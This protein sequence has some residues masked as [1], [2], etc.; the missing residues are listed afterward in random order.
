MFALCTSLTSFN[1][2][3]LGNFAH[4]NYLRKMN[5]FLAGCTSLVSADIST[6]RTDALNEFNSIFYRCTSLKNVYLSGINT[7]G[8]E[9]FKNVFTNCSSLT[10]IDLSVID[11]QNARTFEGMFKGCSS[12]QT[13]NLQNLN[14]EKVNNMS[15]LFCD[16][17]SLRNVTL[18]GTNA[19]GFN[20]YNLKNMSAIFKNCTSLQN[21][22]ISNLSTSNVVDMSE[23][24]SGC[25]G[26]K[27]LD[28]KTTNTDNVQNMN[29]MF[30]NC[31]GL[32][33][34]NITN[35][36]MSNVSSC[37]DFLTGCN[38]LTHFYTPYKAQ[39]INLPGEFY[40]GTN[41][42]DT[43]KYTSITSSTFWEESVH[44]TKVKTITYHSND[45]TS[46]SYKQLKPLTVPVR[47]KT[48]MF[49]EPAGREFICWNTKS[50]GT[51]TRYNVDTDFNVDA[52]TN[53]YAQWKL[54]QYT[55]TFKNGSNIVKSQRVTYGGNAT[56][57][58][59]TKK[60][61]TLTWDK[62]YNNIQTDLVIN[63]VWIPKAKNTYIIQYFK[64]NVDQTGYVL[65]SSLTTT[66]SAVVGTNVYVMVNDEKD[67]EG[68]MYNRNCKYN[69]LSG[70]VTEDNVLVLKM[71]YDRRTVVKEIKDSSGN[72]ITVIDGKY[73]EEIDLPDDI[74][75]KGKKFEGWEDENGNKIDSIYIEDITDNY[76]RPIW[77]DDPD[78]YYVDPKNSDILYQYD[79]IIK[80]K[81]GTKV[82]DLLDDIDTN[83]DK[84][85]KDKYGNELGDNDKVKT[86]DILEIEYEGEI[87][88][89]ELVV[90]GDV[91]GDGLVSLIDLSFINQ[92]MIGK[93]KLTGVKEK[94]ADVNFDYRI[95]LIDLSFVNQHMIGKTRL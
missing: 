54:K 77:T 47:V 55:V 73:G 76:P 14:T 27:K 52:D 46:N 31:T 36:N 53:L 69:V 45:G 13:I 75:K 56:P 1:P 42:E 66:K 17:T 74:T 91:N 81:P 58:S 84:R 41:I 21:I 68:F 87:H 34:L 72:V 51:G 94:A 16:C 5:S 44:L 62:S 63:A 86:G 70:K 82:D 26:L 32:T 12:L 90:R 15:Q 20:T 65:D 11:T 49:T 40:N 7:S 59:I 83:G 37:N 4:R 95:S 29:E 2:G 71:Y 78:A 92:H 35:F 38:S 89:Y 19:Y 28:L 67:I 23:L 18:K 60:D 30:K 9:Q 85:I 25:T 80:I 43:K 79:Y 93:I 24:F 8:I 39:T 33:E 88:I 64:Q 6:I 22:D 57:P 50:D 3:S 48:F 61:Y 10:N